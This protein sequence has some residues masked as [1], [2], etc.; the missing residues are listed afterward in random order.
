MLRDQSTSRKRSFRAAMSPPLRKPSQNDASASDSDLERT[1]TDSTRST[2]R[3]RNH[4]PWVSVVRYSHKD[5]TQPE[6]ES[7]L[8]E[9]ADRIMH[10]AGDYIVK[11]PL[12]INLGPF[13]R[14]H[15]VSSAYCFPII[16]I[17]NLS[18]VFSKKLT[19]FPLR[20]TYF[21]KH[22]YDQQVDYYRCPL[23]YTTHCPMCLQV[24]RTASS[25]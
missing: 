12:D 7:L 1:A 19:S 16:V 9:E 25:T 8:V 18:K 3:Q 5:H 4:F 24:R 13:K 6:I 22:K 15:N 10:V 14:S 21:P 23:H 2:T 11:R 17:S 20:Q